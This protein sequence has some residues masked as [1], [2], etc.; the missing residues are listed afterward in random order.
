MSKSNGQTN[1]SVSDWRRNLPRPIYS[2]LEKAKSAQEWFE[3]YRIRPKIF[4]LYEPGQFEEVISYLV[5][6]DKGAALIDTGMGIGNV[7]RLAEELT[8]LPITVVNTHSHYDHIAQDY[9]FSEIAIFDA[10][11]ARQTSEDGYSK[12]KMKPLLAKE[13]LSKALPSNFDS[14]NYCVPPFVVSRWLKDEDVVDLGGTRLEVIHTPGHSPDSICLLDRGARLL[15]TGDT[16]YP[17]AL[18]VHFPTSDLNEFISS[19]ER[20]NALAPY[21]DA[22]LPSHNEPLVEKHELERVLH[23]AR[24]V[25]SSTAEYVEVVESGAKAR[26]YDYERFAI[27]TKALPNAN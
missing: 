25:K 2:K 27:L 19:Y 12:S 24:K 5:L 21:Y 16:Y 4:A 26:R 6:G 20:I 11:I 14:L 23:A 7:K 15:W 22:L 17:G 13:L 18:Y 9:L 10:P 1:S 3:V 8:E